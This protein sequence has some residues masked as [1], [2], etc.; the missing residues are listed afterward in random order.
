MANWKALLGKAGGG[1]FVSTNAFYYYNSRLN[2]IPNSGFRTLSGDADGNFYH[3]TYRRGGSE[4]EYNNQNRN[5]YSINLFDKDANYQSTSYVWRSDLSSSNSFYDSNGMNIFSNSDGTGILTNGFMEAAYLNSYYP[6]YVGEWSNSNFTTGPDAQYAVY[7]T[8]V[9]YQL[10]GKDN[11]RIDSNGNNII[12]HRSR[13]SNANYTAVTKFNSDFSSVSWAKY[14]Q[15]GTNNN[16]YFDIDDNDNIYI[17]IEND[18]YAK[19]G[20]T[21]INS[22]GVVQWSKQYGQWSDNECE[23]IVYNA[24]TDEV[25]I[26]ARGKYINGNSDRSIILYAVDAANGTF[27]WGNALRPAQQSRSIYG[28]NP[29]VDELGNIYVAFR[30]YGL[31]SPGG[32][33]SSWGAGGI[34]SVE[35]DGTMRYANAFDPDGKDSTGGREFDG[36]E[37]KSS[38]YDKYTDTVLLAGEGNPSGTSRGSWAARVPADGSLTSTSVEYAMGNS[39]Y[40]V[41]YYSYSTDGSTSGHLDY[42]SFTPSTYTWSNTAYSGYT[43]PTKTTLS[44]SDGNINDSGYMKIA[45]PIT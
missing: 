35:S 45:G 15:D 27:S 28:G 9:W 8:D 20:V 18:N 17:G 5:E 40:N 2:I 12:L 26:V 23:G 19:N 16:R 25:V 3:L 44:L 4:P 43:N 6:M 39:G 22:S 11:W 24:A 21:K 34:F 31:Y 41:C 29:T 13:H 42:A 32:Y 14:F 33:R 37:C 10:A 30:G 36:F 7:R 1:G 38:A